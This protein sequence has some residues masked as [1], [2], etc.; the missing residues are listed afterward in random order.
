MQR[1]IE[2]REEKMRRIL[3]FVVFGLLAVSCGLGSDH[4]DATEPVTDASNTTSPPESPES[5]DLPCETIFFIAIDMEGSF[6][7]YATPK[8]AAESWNRQP[9]VPRGEWVQ[10]DDN[11]WVLLGDEGENAART[12]VNVM[13]GNASTTF[14][15][16]RYFSEEVEYCE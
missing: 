4:E 14:P 16:E 5:F 7:G 6:E 3:M 12:E 10:F 13:T 11:K 2:V 9:G 15:T 1:R 8:E